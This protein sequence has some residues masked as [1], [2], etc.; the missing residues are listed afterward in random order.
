VSMTPDFLSHYYEA[1]RGPFRNLSHLAVSEAEEI[2]VE[3]QEAGQVFAAARSVDYL[4]IRRDLEDQVRVLFIARGG[5]PL[6]ARPH[7]MVL[8]SCP[9]LLDWYVD[10][11]EL[12]IPMNAFAR[13]RVSFTY[14]DTFPAMRRQDGKPYRG[15]VFTF[16]DLPD[17]L[18]TYGLPKEWNGDGS[19]GPD[20]YIEA[21]VWYDAPLLPYLMG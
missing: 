11:R 18:A 3:I 7:Y 5:Q 16:D 15:R 2:M 6:L 21:Q 14:G 13:D 8:G 19:G 20:R 17:L 1:T 12:R 9:W 4:T 10:G